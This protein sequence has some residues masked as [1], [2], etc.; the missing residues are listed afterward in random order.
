MWE[1]MLLPAAEN[2]VDCKCD[3]IDSGVINWSLFINSVVYQL[4]HY[5]VGQVA[6]AD[7]GLAHH[8]LRLQLLL[9]RPLLLHPSQNFDL[10]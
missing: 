3:V 8:H 10:W 4:P 6:A 7:P 9:L 2:K 5:G 1:R